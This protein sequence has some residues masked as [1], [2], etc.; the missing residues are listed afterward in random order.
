MAKQARAVQTWRSIVD[1]AASVFD[2]YGYER[3]A[4]SEILPPRQGHQG[5]LVLPLRLQG[6]DRAGDHGRADLHGRVRAG[7]IAAPVPGGR[8]PAVRFALRHNAMA[9]PA[10]GS[11]S[12]A[13]S[14]ADRIRGA[15]GSTRRPGC[16]SW[17]RSGAR[18]SRRSTRWCRPK[19]SSPGSTGIQLVSEADSGRADLREQVGDVAAHPPVDRPPGCHRPHQARGPGGSGGP[20]AGE[21]GAGGAG[22]PDC[23]EAKEAGSDPATDTGSR[24]GGAGL[25][26][27]GPGRGTRAGQG[28]DES[29]EAPGRGGGGGR[30]VCLI[31]DG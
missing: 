25:R 29:D 2:D 30:R 27:G 22:G 4:I 8:R 7:G 15:S 24:S 3:A 14:S 5:G 20:G 31:R 12:R 1:A 23:A 6:G 11:P 9:G 17:G 26:G 28:G 21:G 19:S 16:W 18:C 13:S 10:P